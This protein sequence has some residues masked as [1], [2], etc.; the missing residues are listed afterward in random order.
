MSIKEKIKNSTKLKAIALYL[1]MPKNQHR[2]RLWVQWFWNSW[3]HKHG[4]GAVIRRR[5]RIDVL[6][7]NDFKIG[8]D[9]L[10]EDFATINNQVGAIIIG[11]RTLIGISCVLI[12]PVKIGNNVL[13]AQHVVLSGIN[14][15]FENIN[16]P[17]NQ[18]ECTTA[19]IIIEDEVWIGANAVITAGITVGKHAVI[20]AGSVVTKNVPPFTVVAGNPARILKQ[21]DQ[22]SKEWKKVQYH[23]LFGDEA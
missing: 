19:E 16:I 10:I 5:T 2:P 23:K 15:Q 20:A 12:G 22:E 9:T 21:Y 14:H 18:Q 11:D 17:I 4:K 13:L 7:F 8:K 3:K 6:P 1:L